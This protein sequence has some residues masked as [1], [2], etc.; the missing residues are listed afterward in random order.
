MAED[1]ENT[2]GVQPDP[3]TGDILGAMK[4]AQAD[5]M[6]LYQLQQ[7]QNQSLESLISLQEFANDQLKKQTQLLEGIYKYL[8]KFAAEQTRTAERADERAAPNE[9]STKA[10]GAAY[11]QELAKYA[12]EQAEANTMLGRYTSML[13]EMARSAATPEDQMAVLESFQSMMN[14]IQFAQQ[15]TSTWGSSKGALKAGGEVVGEMAGASV[16]GAVGDALGTALLPAMGPLGLVVGEVAGGIVGDAVEKTIGKAFAALSE[17]TEFLELQGRKTRDQVINAGFDKIRNDLRD[18]S[19][20]AIDVYENATQSI[21]QSW[22]KNVG[23]ITA[24][25]GYTKEALNTLQDSV[26]QKLDELGYSQ[27]INTADYLDQLS[28]VLNANLNDTLAEAFAT[29]SLIL[30]KAVPEINITDMAAEFAAIY[31]NAQRQGLDAEKAM[32]DAMNQ[33]AGA[34]KAIEQ[35]TEGNN[36][37]IRSVPA[38]LSQA[39]EIVARAGGSVDNVAALTTQM[40][41]A[42]GPLAALAPQLSGFTGELITILTNQNDATAVALRSIMHDI[43]ADIGISATDFMTSFMEDTQDTLV[44][45]FQ[46]IDEFIQ[47]NENPAARQE[48]LDAMESLFGIQSEKLAQLDFGYIGEQLAQTN[49]HLNTSALLDAE[50]LV[51]SGETTTLEE[52][53]VNNT[54]NMLLAQNAVRDTLDNALMRKLEK[55]ELEMERLVYANTS[56]Q[57]VDLA[58]NT[59]KF[60]TAVKDILVDL[61]DPFGLFKAASSLV[62]DVQDIEYAQELYE[63]TARMSSIGSG[64]G[65]DS[66]AA[67]QTGIN[68]TE[69]AENLIK[70][71]W[72][73]NIVDTQDLRE[74]VDSVSVAGS[75]LDMYARQNQESLQNTMTAAQNSFNSMQEATIGNYEN[76]Q[77]Q[78]R[79]EQERQA[80]EDE[81]ERQRQEAAA[82]NQARAAEEAQRA[83]DNHDNLSSIQQDVPTIRESIDNATEQFRMES[84]EER[85]IIQDNINSFADV[86]TDSSRQTNEHLERIEEDGIG[87]VVD[88]IEENKPDVSRLD[89]INEGV[90]RLITLFSTYLEFLDDQLRESS[91]TGLTMSSSDYAQIMGRGLLV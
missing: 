16:G 14:S 27:A 39:Q 36:Q 45:A 46:A 64:V 3:E 62:D 13:E 12:A 59:M 21:Y 84:E 77:E 61:L 55:N 22:D 73:Q 83:Q 23:N 89:D 80:K 76:T 90:D 30:Q 41:A 91:G 24:T 75:T 78:Q 48:F 81:Q 28:T 19:T 67:R 32:I 50:A 56:T 37:F 74:A 15:A 69:G 8:T 49:A 25:M 29:Q 2:S 63:K 66:A 53:L 40:M 18:M 26:A 11:F 38:Y 17:L 1:I 82:Q 6:S 87:T 33:V 86:Y 72:K 51:Q 4:A 20:Y 65:S 7:I 47:R 71:A 52:Q 88:A 5:M 44:T 68:T 9:F 35:T 10:S 70:A 60:F 42:E 79:R 31:T 34:V 54:A 85:T 43:N 57:S 58:Q